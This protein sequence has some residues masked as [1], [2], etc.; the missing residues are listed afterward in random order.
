MEK[1]RDCFVTGKWDDHEDAEKLLND[2]GKFVVI[3]FN[4]MLI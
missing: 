3:Y 1:I 4:C 2:D